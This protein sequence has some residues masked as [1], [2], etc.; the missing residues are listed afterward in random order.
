MASN[1]WQGQP[2]SNTLHTRLL[3][4]QTLRKQ[5]PIAMLNPSSRNPPPHCSLFNEAFP[6]PQAK[7]TTP[8]ISQLQIGSGGSSNRS[9]LQ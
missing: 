5:Q 8:A 4:P 7:L 6:P 9:S 1:S 3:Q 2:R